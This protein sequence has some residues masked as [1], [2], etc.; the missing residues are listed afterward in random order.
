MDSV[1]SGHEV[2]WPA[3]VSTSTL[4]GPVSSQAEPLFEV[5][6]LIVGAGASGLAAAE[7]ALDEGA[8]VLLLERREKWG[9]AGLHAGKWFGVDTRWQAEAG[10]EDSL[11]AAT[12]GWEELTRCGQ[13]SHPMVQA[14]LSESAAVLEWADELGAGFA[15][16]EDAWTADGV[17]RYHRI[18][19]PR[20][21]PLFTLGERLEDRV[22]PSTAVLALHLGP[23]GVDGVWLEDGWARADAV[24]VATGGWAR[25]EELVQRYLPEL[26]AWEHSTGAMHHMDGNGV[27][28]MEQVGA[29]LVNMEAPSIYTHDV[30]DPVLGDPE[31]LVLPWIGQSLIVDSQGLRLMNEQEGN[32]VWGGEVW[33]DRG[34]LYALVSQ[35]SAEDLEALGLGYNYG[36]ADS[37]RFKLGELAGGAGYPQ[38]QTV[39][40]LAELLGMEE[41]EATVSRYEELVQAGVDEDFGKD[42]DS[43]IGLGQELIAIPLVPAK[44]KSFGG[45]SLDLEGRVLDARLQ[46]IPGLYAAGEAAG[47]LGGVHVGWGY[48]GSISGVVWSGQLA[49]RHAAAYAL[50]D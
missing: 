44:A 19:T 16:V 33:L 36:D 4:S 31:V 37:G 41:L 29:Q 46:P 14:Y 45:A 49:G 48:E 1:V 22:L 40:E 25:N 12:A 6:V 18:A 32:V 26:G 8:E 20:S 34:P 13:G 38:A 11:E 42:S 2:R 39:G 17:Q 23:E 43:L 3:S 5:D 47:I 24:I 28:M 9:G 35:T 15:L 7:A 30:R 27:L 10:V 50:E 21:G